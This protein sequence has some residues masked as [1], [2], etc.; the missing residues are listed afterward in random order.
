MGVLEILAERNL[1]AK[2]LR[3]YST[4]RPGLSRLD[5]KASH[6][7]KQADEFEKER[8]VSIVRLLNEYATEKDPEERE[9]IV[10]SL[11]EIVLNEP[12]ELP[13]QSLEDWESELKASDKGY[14]AAH[15]RDEKKMQRF[16]RKYFSLRAKAGLATQADVAREAGLRRSYIAVIETGQHFPQQKTLQK[17]AKAFRV[18]VS[19]LA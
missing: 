1:G 6:N 13:V 9:N 10:R 16:L 8:I 11:K 17:L 14:A 18:D 5:R 12:L 2:A 4:L 19:A 7:G 15:A 3:R